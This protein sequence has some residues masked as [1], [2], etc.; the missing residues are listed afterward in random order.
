MQVKY[1][2]LSGSLNKKLSPLYL[3]SG[4]ELLIVQESC[5]CVIEAAK[6][7]GYAER[8]VYQLGTDGGWDAL[9][10]E[11][12]SLSLFSSKRVID[13][14]LP[15]NK[16]DK[17][18]SAF[19]RS[20]CESPPE[21]VLLLIRTERLAPRQRSAAWFKAL[22]SLGVI[23]L[24]WPLTERELPGWLAARLKKE[25]VE[26]DREG[27]TYL[28]EKVEG[29]LLSAAQLVEKLVLSGA[30]GSVGLEMLYEFVE[31]SSRFS[32]F[33][34]IDAMMAG[35][36]HRV[37]HVFSALKE[38]GVSLFAILGAL[39]SQIRRLGANF[40][41][42]PAG[43]RRLVEQFFLRVRTPDSILAEVALIDHQGKGGLKGSDP[44]ISLERLMLNLSGLEELSV[45][46]EDREKL[47]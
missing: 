32:V 22:D 45:L 34:L 38:E 41:S 31:D 12:S 4:D 33:D 7:E 44:W 11:A 3:V 42:V 19:L 21:D 35:R 15:P 13:V 23:V 1:Q 30:S 6:A 26:L 27:L 47:L 37:A 5:D 25:G 28:A 10:E 40:G 43:K 8:L 17:D 20:W 29:N 36:P 18:A 39:A 9:Q 14:R 46:S 24:I 2:N 16:L